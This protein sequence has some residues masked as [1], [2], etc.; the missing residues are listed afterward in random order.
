M[1]VGSGPDRG[2]PAHA[3]IAHLPPAAA[4]ALAQTGI[5]PHMSRT[6]AVGQKRLVKIC[7]TDTVVFVPLPRPTKFQRV[8]LDKTP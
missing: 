8:A 1:D 2:G 6:V 3:A 5:S 7:R 4:S